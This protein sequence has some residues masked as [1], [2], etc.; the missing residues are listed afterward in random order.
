MIKSIRW[1]G[2]VQTRGTTEIHE[3]R[4]WSRVAL[5]GESGCLFWTDPL[6]V[7]GYGLIWNGARSVR[8]HQ[9]SWQLAYGDPPGDDR[10]HLDHLC[11]TN[12]ASCPGGVTCP[13]RSCVNPDHLEWVTP[14]ENSR[15]ALIHEQCDRGHRWDEQTP[16]MRD[17]QRRCRL[18]QQGRQAGYRQQRREATPP[19]DPDR[20][21][22][23]RSPMTHLTEADVRA[24]RESPLSARLAGLQYGL[25][26]STVTRIRTRATWA[27]VA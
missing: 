26:S 14:A 3:Q 6:S 16:I 13:H 21:R 17:G 1:I 27:H 19:R 4:F 11:H 9:F 12:D 20:A 15:R 18:C 10:I 2:G 24:I 23:E 5:P 25:S 22:G 7:G 8:A